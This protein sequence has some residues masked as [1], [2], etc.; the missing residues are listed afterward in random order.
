MQ[1][2]LVLVAE[3]LSASVP[4]RLLWQGVDLTVSQGERVALVGPSGCGKTTLL[5][6][7][8]G[9]ESPDEGR[10][11]LGETDLTRARGCTLRRLRRE[12]M[13]VLF[14]DHG[15]VPTQ[16]IRQNL[17]YGFGGQRV[18]R[19]ERARR[20]AAALEQVGI[21]HEEGRKTLTLSGGEQQRVALARLLVQRPR[22]V[23]ADEPTASLDGGNVHVVQQVFDD[24]ASRG[25]AVVMATHDDRMMRWVDSVLDLTDAVERA[26]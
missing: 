6:C 15:L 3:G 25:T 20:R 26:A 17:D 8:A 21:P 19:D 9:L 23:F 2:E 18:S 1:N 10:V 4:V 14:Q 5:N 22:I 11:V 12:E 7:L 13:G 16:T 24:M